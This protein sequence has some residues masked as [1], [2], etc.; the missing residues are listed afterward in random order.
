M[1]SYHQCNEK[2]RSRF[3]P[4]HIHF[5]AP[6]R[7]VKA[8]LCGAVQIGV[9]EQ[10]VGGAVLVLKGTEHIGHLVNGLLQLLLIGGD[11]LGEDIG[12][13]L[14]G[15]AQVQGFLIAGFSQHLKVDVNPR[16]P[17]E[18]SWFPRGQQSPFVL[19]ILIGM[20]QLLIWYHQ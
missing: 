13:I 7:E 18:R 11:G 12:V 17:P 16:W 5:K 19:Q 3:A 1:G 10:R 4:A 20:Q 6:R 8:V 15:H 9:D 2:G 14:R